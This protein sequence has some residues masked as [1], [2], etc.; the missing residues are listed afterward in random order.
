MLFSEKMIQIPQP[1]RRAL[2]DTYRIL[3]TALVLNVTLKKENRAP[4][5]EEL[6]PLRDAAQTAN[7]ILA[8][9]HF[10]PSFFPEK[11]EFFSLLLEELFAVSKHPSGKD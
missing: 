9:F 7:G 3:C 2:W 5:E 10:P 11:D 8:E 6:R 1:R 4:T